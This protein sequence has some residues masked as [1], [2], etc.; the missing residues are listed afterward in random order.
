MAVSTTRY[1]V[2]TVT[3]DSAV[4]HEVPELSGSDAPTVDVKH[5][6][7]L[8]P[9]TDH[10]IDGVALRTLA[11]P[12][13][14]LLCRIATVN[15]VHF[16]ETEA[17][18]ID[19]HPDGPIMRALPGEA[20][21]PETMNHAAAAEIAAIDPVAVIVKGDLSVDGRPEEFAAFEACYGEAFGDRLH[22]VRGNHDSYRHQ[23]DYAGDAWIELPGINIALVDTA[24]PGA[25]TGSL[26]ATQL[27]WIE[28]HAAESTEPVIV[29]GHHQQWIASEGGNRSD[30]YFGLHP[31]PSDALDEIAQR[32]A[33]IIA[34]TAGHTHRHRLRSMTRSGVASIEIGCTK[35]FPGT[36]AEYRV[37]ET[38][39]MQVVHRISDPAALSW[40]ARCRSLYRDFGIDYA[41]Y[42][43]GTLQD[44]CLVIGERR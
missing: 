6:D 31:D 32:R 3:D 11:R 42:A 8:E 23:D 18:R 28:F 16:G 27:E 10:D 24:I 38:G 29:M 35:D 33:S 44:R 30:S 26:S 12:S 34:Y 4:L 41:S 1:E 36:W 43:L 17:G 22:V 25:T 15:D 2:T 19:D 20:P 13:G 37:Y 39:V 7:G 5:L 21:Y 40:S 14:E 9:D